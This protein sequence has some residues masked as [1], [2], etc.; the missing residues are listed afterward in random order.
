[1]TPGDE[2][3]A[4]YEQWRTLT[5]DEGRA[6][7]AEVWADVEHCQN[8]KSRLQPR[9]VEVSRRLEQ[10]LHDRQF[11]PVLKELMGLEQRNNALLRERRK[12]ADGAR[13]T[14]DRSS[15]NL[16]QLHKSYVP[17]ART[18]WQSYS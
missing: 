18:L 13:E 4:L 11:K 6:I 1:M 8:A 7:S 10:D 3:A 15:R 12:A 9:I 17:P 14:L 5:E 2:L 16:R